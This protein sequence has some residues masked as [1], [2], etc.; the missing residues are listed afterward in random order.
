MREV[1]EIVNETYFLLLVSKHLS[2]NQTKEKDLKHN[3]IDYVVGTKQT[4]TQFYYD[5]RG[6]W[7]MTINSCVVWTKKQTRDWMKVDFADFEWNYRWV[8]IK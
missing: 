2:L 6:L 3:G 8:K 5:R 7:S 1:E 4:K